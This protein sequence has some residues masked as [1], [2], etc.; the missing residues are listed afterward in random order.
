MAK[1]YIED[2][3]QSYPGEGSRLTLIAMRADRRIIGTITG[4]EV[5]T[6]TSEPNERPVRFIRTVQFQ[7]LFVLPKFRRLGVGRL[8]IRALEKRAKQAV[9]IS[10][11]VKPTNK[12]ALSFY[13]RMGYTPA[14]AYDDG[15]LCLVKNLRKS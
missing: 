13:K 10:C 15:D 11:Y 12:G 4:K 8:L 14:F 6:V 5:L 7:S 9:S 2:I 3:Y 1:T